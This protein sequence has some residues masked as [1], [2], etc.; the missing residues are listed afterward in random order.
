MNTYEPEWNYGPAF[1]DARHNF[2]LSANYELPFGR[3][4]RGADGQPRHGRLLG[5]WRL[6]GIFQART[7]FPI[8]VT[9]GRSR[10]QQGV[11]GNERPNCVGDPG[12][13]GPEHQPLARHQRVLACA[14][15]HV[16]NCGSASRRAP[17]ITTSTRC[18]P[19]AS[20]SAASATRVPG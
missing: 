14:A 20:T 9:D 4:G 12:P 13:R 6:S 16:G 15:G 5:G 11:R 2:V 7:G 8:T 19:S 3:G 17:A 18:W 10:S 1:F